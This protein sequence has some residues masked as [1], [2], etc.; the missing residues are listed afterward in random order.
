[1][2]SKLILSKRYKYQGLSNWIFLEVSYIAQGLEDK[3][4]L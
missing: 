4:M 2:F 3:L 1:M